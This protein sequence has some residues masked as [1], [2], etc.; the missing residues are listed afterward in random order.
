M[1]IVAIVAH[2]QPCYTRPEWPADVRWLPTKWP[3]SLADVARRPSAGRKEHG[4]SSSIFPLGPYHPAWPLP[5]ALTI[6]VRGEQVVGVDAPL[7]GFCRRGVLDLTAG[8]PI[9][10]VL[11]VIERSCALAG[12]AHRTALCEA[13][14]AATA[15]PVARSARVTR[16]L[17]LEVE[18]ILARLWLLA[19]TARALGVPA[20]ERAALEQREALFA[21]VE[22]VTA[23]RVFWAIAV[24]GGVRAD[25]AIEPVDQALRQ[26]A[27]E[28]ETWHAAVNPRGPLGGAGSGMGALST[29]RARVLGL[30]GVAAL[31]SGVD[32][33]RRRVDPSGGY[34]DLPARWPAPE[35]ASDSA[36]SG[37]VVA[38]LSAVV[39]D[40][41][42]SLDI[43]R[44][45]LD[46]LHDRPA[47]P[48]PTPVHASTAARTGESTIAGPHGPV[49]VAIT[50]AP[51]LTLAV[52][53]LCTAVEALWAALPELVDGRAVGQ[54]PAILASL[55]LC[56]EC[57]DL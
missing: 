26:V 37:D 15:T 40:M 14:E 53:A 35:A 32:D 19:L 29:E 45:C 16:V 38:R 56:V 20:P 3:G 4:T 30:S 11:V 55:D 41:A 24:P 22:A 18:R 17:F 50:L 5:A 12:T 2:G 44:A 23:E 21:A 25:L 47:E 27:A 28:L 7:T 48:A 57:R 43:T 42:I 39:A 34:A 54:V 1:A 6:R 49:T 13:I 51:D 10:D 9:E 46:A 8:Q 52:T 36:T 33:D 31:G